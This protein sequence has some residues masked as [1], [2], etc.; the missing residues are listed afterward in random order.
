MSL[1]IRTASSSVEKRAIPATG[2][3]VS[4]QLIAIAGGQP[5]DHGRLEERLPELVARA[6]EV[7]LGAAVERVG[8][9]PLDLLERL[10]VD[11]RADL[12]VRLGAGPT[13]SRVTPATS[14]SRY[15]S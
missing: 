12:H 4:S 15:S 6:A 5:G 14:R 13:A 1:A 3:N 10:R 2:P 9:V 11:Q 7:E 8:D